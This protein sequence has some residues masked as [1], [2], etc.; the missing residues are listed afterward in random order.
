VDLQA[1]IAAGFARLAS[2]INAVD[3]KTGGF[4]IVKKTADENRTNSTMA[5][6]ATL[7]VTLQPGQYRIVVRAEFS[8]ANATM[9]YKYDTNFT[10]TASVKFRKHK[11]IVAG[12]AAGTDSETVT[13]GTGQVPAQSVTATTS[14]VASVEID[15]VLVVTVAGEFQFR[16]AQNT[17]DAGALTCF[18]G[19]YLQY[20]AV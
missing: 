16:W 14:G 18:E 13:V 19:S 17:T 11:H 12:A 2:A 4:T 5:V 20:A 15:L 1:R 10:G 8:A 3:A 6:D 9:D 7:K